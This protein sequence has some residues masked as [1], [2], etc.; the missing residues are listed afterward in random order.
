MWYESF[1]TLLRLDHVL[2]ERPTVEGALAEGSG[3]QTRGRMKALDAQGMLQ[4]L[5][6]AH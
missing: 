6:Y 5:T 4:R 1:I 2:P 3:Q